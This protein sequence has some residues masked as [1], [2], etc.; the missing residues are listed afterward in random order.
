MRKTPSR[1][2]DRIHFVSAKDFPVCC[3]PQDQPVWDMH[4]RVYLPL[5]QMKEVTC[6]YCSARYVLKTQKTQKSKGVSA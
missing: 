6:P 2:E 1:S 5:K 4:P 3:P